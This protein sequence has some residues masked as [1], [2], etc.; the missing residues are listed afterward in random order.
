M[1]HHKRAKLKHTTALITIIML[2]F[3]H[4][5]CATIFNGSS[6]S[7][8]VYS[9]TDNLSFRVKGDTVNRYQTPV[10]IKV[11]RAKEDLVLVAQKDS[12]EQEI[13][14]KSNI[15]GA[16]IGTIFCFW[17]AAIV[18]LSTPKRYTYPSVLID[19]GENPSHYLYN[20]YGKP[21]VSGRS[22]SSASHIT[23]KKTE[24]HT[25]K[26][27]QLNLKFSIPIANHFVLNAGDRYIRRGGILGIAGGFQYYVTNKY[28]LSMEVGTLW[29]PSG[30]WGEYSYT[31]NAQTQSAYTRYGDIQIGSYHKQ[32]HYD[33]GIQYTRTSYQRYDKFLNNDPFP[34]R[35]EY[36]ERLVKQN[37]AGL[38]LSTR[39]RLSNSFYVGLNYYPSFFVFD[40]NH[41]H[42]RYSHS[43]SAGLLW[44][45]KLK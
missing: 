6:T 37:T 25:P 41:F 5:S 36:Q 9:T 11:T 10:R 4:T 1:T 20:G 14:I 38:S 13:A 15:S 3:L 7:I 23:V 31:Q 44:N 18:D 22:Q 40:N 35:T 33:F 27:N 12:I 34:G 17:P 16:F 45:I 24:L 32:W 39:Y 26:N 21:R 19:P 28:R 29:S 8:E 43:L 42:T 30:H 2:A